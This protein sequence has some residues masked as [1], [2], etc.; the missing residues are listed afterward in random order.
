M[1]YQLCSETHW[2][3]KKLGLTVLIDSYI[4]S[5]NPKETL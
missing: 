5:E 4:H 3:K 1:Y 2:K